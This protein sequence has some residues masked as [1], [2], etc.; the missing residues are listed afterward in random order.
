MPSGRGPFQPRHDPADF[1]LL[2]FG[3]SGP[4]QSAAVM[5]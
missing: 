3:G 5:A 1:A 2:S 4:A